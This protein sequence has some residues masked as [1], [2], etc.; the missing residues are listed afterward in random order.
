MSL[1]GTVTPNPRPLALRTEV[2]SPWHPAGMPANNT[3]LT[4]EGL[5]KLATA[6]GT[7][8]P[9][10]PTPQAVTLIGRTVGEIAPAATARSQFATRI[11]VRTGF[12]LMGR[13]IWRPPLKL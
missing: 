7:N 8:G 12:A 9:A 13:L 2:T 10:G 6:A 5:K 1:K 3:G 11:S 4:P